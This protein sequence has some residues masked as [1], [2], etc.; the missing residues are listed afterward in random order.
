MEL[1]QTNRESSRFAD[2]VGLHS[3]G[4]KLS[5]PNHRMKPVLIQPPFHHTPTRTQFKAFQLIF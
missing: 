2:S 4:Q 3:E 5:I 1:D